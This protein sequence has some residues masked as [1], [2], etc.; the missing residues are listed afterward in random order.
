MRYNL[1][2]IKQTLKRYR[3]HGP[4]ICMEALWY[5]KNAWARL[6]LPA[7]WLY[8]AV[9]YVHQK[10]YARGIR[11]SAHFP[12]PIIVVGNLT[13]GG[14]GKTPL[15]IALAQFLL[16][17]GYKPG[18]I[19]RGYKSQSKHFPVF[20]TSKTHTK[21]SGDEPWLIAHK[22]GCPVVIDPN[23]VRAAGALLARQACDVVLS[24]DGLQHLPL[25]RHI[26]IVVV[27]GQRKFG[28]GYCLP[29]GPLREPIARLKTVDFVVIQAKAAKAPGW[30]M[31]FKP[32]PITT[33]PHSCAT[34][35]E[36]KKREPIHAVAAI[37]HPQPFFDMLRTLGF[38]RIQPH[39]FPDHYAYK[40]EDL[41]FGDGK[42]IIM[43]E[44]DAV[45]CRGFADAHFWQLP[46]AAYCPDLLQAIFERLSPIKCIPYNLR[47]KS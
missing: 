32:Q 46:I 40:A 5:R 29:A 33:V 31:H 4:C 19:S 25:A 8:R 2:T 20:V 11:R 21:I 44:K 24:D 1:H 38:T 37:G 6:L 16:Q 45:K 35:P 10:L 13:V 14:T 9:V 28:N 15:I 23:R 26:E 41:A 22:T 17:K 30:G 7:S 36:H 34:F 12:V 27:S 43:T 47:G 42:P 39:I 18:I 3:I